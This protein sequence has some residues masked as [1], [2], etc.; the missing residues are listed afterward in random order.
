MRS[1]DEQ[2]EFL[3]HGRF[4]EGEKGGAHKPANLVVIW[5][6]VSISGL[7]LITLGIVVGYV[8]IATHS[9]FEFLSDH[10]DLFLYS[11]MF[12]ILFAFSG[13]IA[14]GRH[15]KRGTR[16]RVAGLVFAYPWMAHFL[17]APIDGGSIHGP[18]ALLIFVF[19]PATI[20]AVVLLI[21][22]SAK[23]SEATVIKG[24]EARTRAGER[25]E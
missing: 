14:W 15:M 9:R 22:P 19:I 12:G 1:P 21:M 25:G 4:R 8:D 24:A 20:L 7:C 16:S 3:L 11:L 13:L 2:E 6:V 17:G 5:R 18:S 10:F 23:E